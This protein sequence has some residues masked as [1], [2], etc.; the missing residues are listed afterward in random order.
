MLYIALA[1]VDP[2]K[3]VLDSFPI[4]CQRSRGSL[5]CAASACLLCGSH[6]TPFLRSLPQISKGWS[7]A[8]SLVEGV[9][10]AL[11]VQM[12]H[13]R[14]LGTFM[15]KTSQAFER[16]H[17]SVKFRAQALGVV[18]VPSLLW[19][20]PWIGHSTQHVRGHRAYPLGLFESC[21]DI[22]SKAFGTI[23]STW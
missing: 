4:E 2:T 23:P 13:G 18:N 12:P 22:A 15:V 10:S 19:V 16:R 3:L 5:A 9:I 20:Q 8:W 6:S 11:P 17:Y 7:P 14:P 21:W 1:Q